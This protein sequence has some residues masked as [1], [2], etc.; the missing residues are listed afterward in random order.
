MKGLHPFLDNVRTQHA[1]MKSELGFH[2]EAKKWEQFFEYARAQISPFEKKEERILFSAVTGKSGIRAGGPNCL[3]YFDLHLSERPQESAARATNQK[4]FRPTP[5]NVPEHLKSIVS[6]NSPL[7]I[8]L[9]DHFAMDAIL[10]A[11]QDVVEKE[12]EYLA[13]TYFNI[14]TL[15]FE[16]EDRCLLA[17]CQALLSKEELDQCMADDISNKWNN[18]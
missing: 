13:Y 5:G 6:D 11:A 15:H 17:M 9:E 3:L 16:K 2:M 18:L 4:P 8:P 14:L 7:C 12:F 1:R 10:K